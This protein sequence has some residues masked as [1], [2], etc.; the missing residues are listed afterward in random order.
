MLIHSYRGAAKYRMQFLA[1]WG[2]TLTT[3]GAMALEIQD[4]EDFVWGRAGNGNIV[5]RVST[6]KAYDINN[7]KVVANLE[8]LELA[9]AA[10]SASDPNAVYHVSRAVLLYRHPLTNEV[11]LAYPG[12]DP[13]A[14]TLVNAYSHIENA[15]HWRL[16]I[17]S[18]E[19]PPRT[20]PGTVECERQG[21]V[22]HCMRHSS[23]AST[24]GRTVL[25]YRW[26]INRTG[27]SGEATSRAEFAETEP[28]NP[29]ISEGPLMIRLTSYSVSSW[30]AVP[31]S[32]RGW[33]ESQAPQF[34]AL[35]DELTPLIEAAG[36]KP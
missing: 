35:P 31:N 13:N 5:Y 11:L 27:A 22:L 7:G 28:A 8:G 16:G 19:M 2:F 1:L 17:P 18:S 6:G 3:T 10:R 29:L 4:F 34:G 36:F 30:Q 26:S 32:L 9:Q 23:Y 21:P 14:Q 12:S 24:A 25:E 15:F 33:V 20:L